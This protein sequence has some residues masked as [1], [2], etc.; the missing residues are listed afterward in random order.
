[1]KLLLWMGLAE[2]QTFSASVSVTL[3]KQS[4]F[5]DF[6]H[7][8]RNGY[9]WQ[10]LY[11][12]PRRTWPL[13]RCF[14]SPLRARFPAQSHR[15]CDQYCDGLLHHRDCIDVADFPIDKVRNHRILRTYM[16][17]VSRWS[18]ISTQTV[19]IGWAV[20]VIFPMIRMIYSFFKTDQEL[21]F[22]PWTPPLELQWD[23]FARAW[24]N[25]QVG[26]YL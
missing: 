13:H 2:V 9:V 20:T 22:S 18:A 12:D 19:L 21:F 1:M 15:L 11:D 16:Y 5:A 26:D 3:G 25:A 24:T 7:R 4:F 17:Q 6:H 14:G 8:H 23:N 10:Y